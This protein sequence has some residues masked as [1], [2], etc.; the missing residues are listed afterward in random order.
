M[1]R[2]A[3]LHSLPYLRKLHPDVWQLC[4]G[5]TAP[6]T[7]HDGINHKETHSSCSTGTPPTPE[8]ETQSRL[9]DESFAAVSIESLL[10]HTSTTTVSSRKRGREEEEEEASDSVASFGLPAF[11][12]NQTGGKGVA[13]TG[14]DNAL[15]HASQINKDPAMC[16][17]EVAIL[18]KSQVDSLRGN[19]CF[20]PSRRDGMDADGEDD[21]KCAPESILLFRFGGYFVFEVNVSSI[22]AITYQPGVA[23]KS[24]ST[25]SDL[26]N[27]DNEDHAPTKDDDVLPPSKRQRDGK[28]AHVTIK[29]PHSLCIVFPSFCLRVFSVEE[30]IGGNTNQSTTSHANENADRPLARVWRSLKSPSEVAESSLSKAKTILLQ[31]FDV[32]IR[33]ENSPSWLFMSTA[34]E[35]SDV[36]KW[37]CC[38]ATKP[39]DTPE[40]HTRV[41][42]TKTDSSCHSEN[43]QNE[44]TGLFQQEGDQTHPSE[45]THEHTKDANLNT[46]SL[47][48]PVEEKGTKQHSLE[49]DATTE[50]D[51]LMRSVSEKR[52]FFDASWSSLVQSMTD[53]KHY[54]ID[55]SLLTE[56]AENLAGSYLSSEATSILAHQCDQQMERISSDMEVALEQMIPARGRSVE[57]RKSPSKSKINHDDDVSLRKIEELQR[58]HK[59]TMAVKYAMLLCP[60]R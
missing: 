10:H 18:S 19:L 5:N 48:E 56:S 37:I 54:V 4:S 23:T 55:N 25:D 24:A 53:V 33:R 6:A 27:V 14:D 13:A 3:F 12:L 59:E 47:D 39:R 49:D 46:E 15:N 50:I 51:C 31:C 58:M 34:T 7:K 42:P 40:D 38:L 16:S 44:R 35:N 28:G 1:D 29:A 52:S 60:K 45:L 22:E 9:F 2:S 30:A 36:Q 32:G 41:S 43:A 26:T 20:P 17:F 57:S 21:G 11:F 8:N